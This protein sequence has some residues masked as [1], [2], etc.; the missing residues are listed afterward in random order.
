MLCKIAMIHSLIYVTNLLPRGMNL[1]E[2]EGH[3]N[4]YMNSYMNAI[5]SY[6]GHGQVT[7]DMTHT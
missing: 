4:L 6:H 7:L 1:N 3:A 5:A 2:I